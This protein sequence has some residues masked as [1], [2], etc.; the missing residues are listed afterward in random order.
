[1]EAESQ[2]LE[3]VCVQALVQASEQ[4]VHFQLWTQPPPFRPPL[5]KVH[6]VPR[7][8]PIRSLPRPKLTK[9]SST[10]SAKELRVGTC[11]HLFPFVKLDTEPRKTE[12]MR[13]TLERLQTVWGRKSQF[14]SGLRRKPVSVRTDL[15]ALQCRSSLTRQFYAPL[16]TKLLPFRPPFM[17]RTQR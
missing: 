17:D 16:A 3:S 4:Q 2:T 13:V 11:C 6:S 15:Q 10:L 7:L 14:S 12:D 1:M 5:R 8:A 9:V